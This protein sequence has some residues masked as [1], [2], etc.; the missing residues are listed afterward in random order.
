MKEILKKAIE[1]LNETKSWLSEKIKMIN[2]YADTS[3][4]KGR[5]P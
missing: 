1:N 4:K 5:S 2:L 3:G